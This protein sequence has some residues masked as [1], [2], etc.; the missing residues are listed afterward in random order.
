MKFW[1]KII[2]SLCVVLVIVFAVWA[3]FFKEKE[4]VQAYNRTS[5]LID[6]KVSI[7]IKEKLIDLRA[8]DYLHKDKSKVIGN[9]TEDEQNIQLKRSLILSTD[10]IELSANIKIYSYIELDNMLE[11]IIEQNL[12]YTQSNS[13]NSRALKQ[14]KDDIDVYIKT[15]QTLNSTLKSLINYQNVIDGTSAELTVLSANYNAL[16]KHYRESL[17]YGSNV[18][19]SLIN[20]ID[21]SVYG[22]NML[23]DTK[24]AFYDSFIRAL[25]SATAIDVKQEPAYLDDLRIIID[26]MAEYDKGTDIFTTISEYEFLNAYN[27]LYKQHSD[28]LDFLYS[29]SRIKKSNMAKKEGDISKI[30]EEIQP[31]VV[32]ILNIYEF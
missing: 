8:L 30:A 13:V 2:I 22:D 25:Q 28:T 7:G 14:L 12:P 18:A 27:E 5:E 16:Y 6:Y 17:H 32:T 20:Y 15:L 21:K 19:E 24:T 26:K 10:S 23:I 31:M 3:F 9:S 1:V 29:S 11:R 4:N